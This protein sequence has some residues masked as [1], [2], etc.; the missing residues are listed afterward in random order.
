MTL[1]DDSINGTYGDVTFENGVATVTLKG[2]EKAEATGLP[3]EITY[4]ITEASAEGFQLTGKTGD[5]GSI[6]TTKST[7]VFTNTRETGDLE[8][9]KELISERLADKDQKFTFTVTLGDDS[10]NG[11]Y[12]DMTFENGV[13]T[14]EL[15]GGESAEATGLP[16]DISYD[17]T[18]AD[19]D[20]FKLTGVTGDSGTISTEKASAEFTN[21]RKTG[22]LKILKKI[23]VNRVE[24]NDTS[25]VDGIY[26]FDVNGIGK[27]SGVSRVVKIRIDGGVVTKVWID[28]KET[29]PEGGYAVVRDLPTGDY[30]ITERTTEEM[31]HKGISL[32]SG[33][34]VTIRIENDQ[35]PDEIPEEEFLNNKDI[36]ELKLRKTVVGTRDTITVF[37]FNVTLKAPGEVEFE[38]TY[39]AVLTRRNGDTEEFP[40][41]VDENGVIA[42]IML[43]ASESLTIKELPAGTTYETE[44]TFIPDGY[45]LEEVN[46]SGNSTIT[47]AETSEVEFV[48][49]YEAKDTV[50]FKAQK[51]FTN[52][53]LKE[54]PFTIKLSQVEYVEG[55]LVPVSDF[56]PLTATVDADDDHQTVEFNDVKEFVKTAKQDENGIYID[57]DD[58]G[59][60]YF[61]I[62]EVL[63][64]GVDDEHPIKD[65]VR[66]DTRKQLIKVTVTDNC[67]G[68]LNVVKDPAASNDLDVTF[69]NKQLGKI[70]IKKT[71]KNTDDQPLVT[72]DIEY[73]F[74][75]TQV[76]EN[77]EPGT[78]PIT[79]ELKV[80]NGEEKTIEDL[81]L[82]MYTVEETDIPAVNGHQYDGTTLSVEGGA[83]VDEATGTAQTA[84][85]VSDT[86][87][88]V[89]LSN[90][91]TKTLSVEAVNTYEVDKIP[92]AV[93]KVWDDG[94][95]R[96]GVRPLTLTVD[97]LANGEVCRTV[98]LSYD[99]NWTAV[100]KD[101]PVVDLSLKEIVYAWSEHDP[102]NGYTL[103]GT[104][105]DGA[106]TTLTNSRPPEKTTVSVQKVWD[107]QENAAKKRP[108]EITVQLFAN[109][110][111]EG[112]AVTLNEGNGWS[113]SWTDLVKNCNPNGKI[114]GSSPI[115]YTVEELDVPEGYTV[116]RNGTGTS[117][118]ITNT[119]VPG[120]LEIRKTFE[121]EPVEPENPETEIDIPVSKSWDDNDNKDGNRP[122]SVTVRL[123]ADGKE[124]AKA[125]LNEANGWK[126][127]FLNMPKTDGDR[128]IQYTI[129][130]DP[131]EWYEA[132]IN[133]TNIRNI[134][135]PETTSVSV[136][137]VWD[138]HNNEAGMR[139]V[140]IWMTLSNG[141]TILLNEDNGWAATIS[142]LPTKLNGEPVTYT[143][144]EQQVVGYRLVSTKTEGSVTTF[145]N[146]F[147]NVPPVPGNQPQPK[148]PGG[149][150][151]IFEEYDTA[152]GGDI[153]INHVG[154]CFD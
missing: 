100:E 144:T 61:L 19:A 84:S 53:N 98:T 73:T 136:R 21:T 66:Y 38:D 122:E 116:T 89:E 58:C 3:T 113:H 114:G 75:I 97:L 25:L 28:D 127:T 9:S 88:T 63:P 112:P 67:D 34:S 138:D 48:N 93:H 85:E 13:A 10:I 31:K 43:T 132:E 42:D 16:T 26:I 124:V 71:V 52:G 121:F 94:E 142:G 35:S 64:D 119:L 33:N 118:E 148:T 12:G 4:E 60:Y 56:E 18:E 1:G 95:N 153:L 103:T 11:T 78:E 80:K 117:I 7:A 72:E 55:K 39:P 8:L 141:T 120:K 51:I 44:E 107:D 59:N 47:M 125:V 50:S 54:H 14:V 147:V 30:V 137:K 32:I 106:I 145:T 128:K 23:A 115:V 139:P 143:W 101:L 2:G 70:R 15:K 62:E 108:T 129:T 146:H 49:L 104:D 82:G 83:I 123:L 57:R 27:A 149:G 140:S 41:A 133:G 17:I 90:T 76:L 79:K 6:S 86:K 77:A 109:G 46:D 131:V 22:A 87:V 37:T 130:E 24:T 81:P 150:W 99:N 5:T 36:G 102:G 74:R 40:V 68:S 134:Y 65:G 135:V 126:Y 29:A 20:D 92:M 151:V 96:D 69:E 110:K 111:A 152:L 154:D 45:E 105:T 91:D